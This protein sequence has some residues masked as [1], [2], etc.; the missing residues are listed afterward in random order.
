MSLPPG[1]TPLS[2]FAFGPM[3]R[4]A[5]VTL[6]AF[7]L[8]GFARAANEPSFER[9][10]SALFSKLGCN[11]GTCHGSVKGQNGFRLSLLGFEPEVDYAAL[12][13]EA[14]G[15]CSPSFMSIA[16]STGRASKAKGHHWSN[17]H[18]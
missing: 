12:V 2:L 7:A 3:S 11:G 14:R 9:H 5:L 18:P 4:F 16:K 8:P 10:V 17:D 15:R 1:I 6:A 13:K